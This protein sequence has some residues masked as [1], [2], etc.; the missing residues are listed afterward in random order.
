[1]IKLDI[2][3]YCEECMMFDAEVQGPE[4]LYGY[5]GTRETI[6]QSDTIV[7]CTNRKRCEGIRRYLEKEMRGGNHDV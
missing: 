7:R 1:M 5:D 3:P 6:F 2:Q 4:K